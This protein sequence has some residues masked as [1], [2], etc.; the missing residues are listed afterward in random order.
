MRD[1][2][3]KARTIKGK[4]WMY[5]AY[6]LHINRTPC[7]MGDSIQ[8]SDKEHYLICDAFSDWNMPRGMDAHPIY[9][10]TDRKS[11]V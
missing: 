2:I 10:E 4:R 8:E 5:G 1:I 7:P 6:N 9:P 11:V 3:C